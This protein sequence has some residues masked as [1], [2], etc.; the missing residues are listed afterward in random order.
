HERSLTAVL[1]ISTLIN[2]DLDLS[3]M[4]QILAEKVHQLMGYACAVILLSPDELKLTWVGHYSLSD[5]Y[6]QTMNAQSTTLSS[7]HMSQ[8]ATGRA[9]RTRRPAQIN[10]LEES[11]VRP[12]RDAGRKEG[13]ASFIATPMVLHD[14]VLGFINCYTRVPH[15]FSQAEVDLLFIIGNQAAIAVE[16]TRLHDQTVHRAEELARINQ[17]LSEQ[18]H[19][20]QRQHAELLQAEQIHRQLTE[21]I[22]DDGGL[23]AIVER[24]AGL[25]GRPVALYDADVRLLALVGAE[26]LR[27]TTGWTE[28]DALR[29]LHDREKEISLNEALP[30]Q[31]SDGRP[32]FLELCCSSGSPTTVGYAVPVMAGTAVLAYLL[33]LQ[34]REPLGALDLRAVEHG[35]TVV[36][37]ELLKQRAVMET[38]LQLRGG[39]VDD[40]LTGDYEDD[41]A[42][43]QRAGRLGFDFDATY[44]PFVVSPDKDGVDLPSGVPGDV[45]TFRRHLLRLTV[46]AC[47]IRWPKALATLK[48]DAVVVLWPEDAQGRIK[49]EEAARIL[50]DD[51]SRL[52]RTSTVSIGIGGRCRKPPEFSGAFAEARRCIEVL[53]GFRNVDRVLS[54]EELGL[55]RFLIGPDD[56]PELL[57]FAH[58][59][60]DALCEHERRYS[61][62]LL[63]TLN[64]FL[65]TECSLTKA[66]EQLS[67]HINTVQYRVRRVEELTGVRLRSPG[68]LM[69]IHLALLI[70]SLQSDEFPVLREVTAN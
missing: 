56:E 3:S 53:R 36:T 30:R 51:V 43:V 60:L 11:A 29:V 10:D 42:V 52:L 37:L 58:R 5:E 7:P 33:V 15:V 67:V 50:K 1:E 27:E 35:A 45:D 13:I 59:R 6:I 39:F 48:G 16:A 70:A 40:L 25:V 38:E 69:E 66:A 18:N 24:I 44:R 28:I 68:G 4:F 26:E 49:S 23:S 46:A 19:L 31:L 55:H 21:V 41:A 61:G 47:A 20:L 8:G 62:G 63:H 14:R 17:V 9:L 65:A 34:T 32:R 12:W 57:A 22:L 2:L 64:V 54:V